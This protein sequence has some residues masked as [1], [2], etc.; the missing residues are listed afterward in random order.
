MYLDEQAQN[1]MG[2]LGKSLGN[3]CKQRQTGNGPIVRDSGQSI[4]FSKDLNCLMN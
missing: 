3:N 1:L 2:S 4:S